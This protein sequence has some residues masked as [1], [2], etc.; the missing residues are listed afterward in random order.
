[1]ADSLRVRVELC[2]DGGRGNEDRTSNSSVLSG[3]DDRWS[4]SKTERSKVQEHVRLAD[5]KCR[6]DRLCIVQITEEWRCAQRLYPRRSVWRSCEC[7]HAV[8]A[9][10]EKWEYEA[11]EKSAATSDVNS[12]DDS[13]WI[14]LGGPTLDRRVQR[15]QGRTR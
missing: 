13:A 7:S 3:G 1:M 9:L 14:E 12:H 5:L 8:T 11:S 15:S 10:N 4:V 2:E 6:V